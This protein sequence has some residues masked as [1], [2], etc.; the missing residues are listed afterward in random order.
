MGR[1]AMPSLIAQAA[2]PSIGAMLMERFGPDVTLVALF[3]TAALNVALVI[4]LFGLLL[5]QGANPLKY[6]PAFQHTVSD[7]PD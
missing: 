1:I 6:T 5:R 3:T 7:K 2:A 4:V